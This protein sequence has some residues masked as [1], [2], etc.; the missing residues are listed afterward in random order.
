[1]ASPMFDDDAPQSTST[2]G[3]ML[4]L[5][6]GA[7]FVIAAV[8]VVYTSFRIDVGTGEMAILIHKTGQDVLNGDELAPG[9]ESKGVQPEVLREG[10]YFRNPLYWDWEVK[11]QTVIPQG[12]LGVLISLAGDDLPYGEFLARVDAQERVITKGI[13]PKVLNP[14]RY[15]IN[16]YLFEVELRDPQ[17]V[18]AGYRGVVTNLAGPL[19]KAPNTLLVE[20]GERGVQKETLDSGTYYINPFVTRINLVDCRSQRFNISQN[21]DMGFPSKDG[22]WI[23]LDGVIEFRVDPKRA[24]EIY[25]IYNETGQGERMDEE[26]IR[27][28]LLPNARSFCRLQGSN[29]LGREFISGETR[30]QFQEKFQQ[31]MKD[32]CEPLGVEII[33]ALITRIR[34]P[35]QIAKPVREREL[36]KQQEKQYQQQILQQKSEER[37]AVE[38]ELVKQKQALVQ[39]EQE[40]VKMTVEAE[41]LQEVAVTKANERLGVAQFKLDAAK[42]E[43]SATL[44]KGKAD[45]EV[46][47]FQNQ[48]DA[49]GWSR[50]VQAFDGN[51]GLYAQ[52]VLFQKLSGAYRQIMANTADS[53][54]MKVFESFNHPATRP[55][56]A[57]ATAEETSE[58]VPV[59]VTS[60]RGTRP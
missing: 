10:R 23:S 55:A 59:K 22:F 6:A 33:Q 27:K 45:A 49:A 1:M 8:W 36:A 60:D 46:V 18:P 57:S 12:K 41:R 16:P 31:A 44:A 20:P 58:S 17:T 56:A 38:K 43:A 26:L 50:S 47:H 35:E 15:P 51:G 54:I 11:P 25:V 30:T 2:M 21:K 13:V 48:A 39:A 9:M 14:G 52:Y 3:R 19:P 37:L 32:A 40:V 28:V 42:D 29:E 53:P 5:L 24:A 4:T 7:V 34:P